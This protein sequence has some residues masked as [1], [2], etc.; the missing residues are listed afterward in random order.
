MIKTTLSNKHY[1][2]FY[3]RVKLV[4]LFCKKKLNDQSNLIQF[5]KD[6]YV[7][8]KRQPCLKCVVQFFFESKTIFSF[9]YSNELYNIS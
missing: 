5:V 1:I 4:T 7:M 3:S 9:H 2:F 6:N 8:V